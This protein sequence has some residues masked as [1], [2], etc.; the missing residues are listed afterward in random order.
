MIYLNIDRATCVR[1]YIANIAEEDELQ[2]ACASFPSVSI[3]AVAGK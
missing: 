1:T 3:S 2:L